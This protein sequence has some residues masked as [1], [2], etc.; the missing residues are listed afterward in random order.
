MDIAEFVKNF[1][2]NEKYNFKYNQKVGGTYKNIEIL[3][4]EHTA[5]VVLEDG[6]EITCSSAINI[7]VPIIIGDNV[8]ITSHSRIALHNVIHIGNNV[9]FITQSD[10]GNVTLNMTDVDSEFETFKTKIG[11]NLTISTG[12][13]DSKQSRYKTVITIT[14]EDTSYINTCNLTANSILIM[15]GL[16]TIEN[17]IFDRCKCA[18]FIVDNYK[19]INTPTYINVCTDNT[20]QLDA[21]EI[22]SGSKIKAG[23]FMYNEYNGYTPNGIIGNDVNIITKDSSIKLH[24]HSIGKNVKLQSDTMVKLCNIATLPNDICIDTQMLKCKEVSKF[25]NNSK[26]I[27][28][29]QVYLGNIVNLPSYFT[30]A[31]IGESKEDSIEY[32]SI[33]SIRSIPSTFPLHADCSLSINKLDVFDMYFPKSISGSLYL[34]IAHIPSNF[35]VNVGGKL[36]V[37]TFSIA[38]N[39]APKVGGDM[40]IHRATILGDKFMPECN[41]KLYI[42]NDVLLKANIFAPKADKIVL[43]VKKLQANIDGMVCNKFCADN[44][45][46][47]ETDFSKCVIKEELSL[48]KASISASCDFITKYIPVINIPRAKIGAGYKFEPK[49]FVLYWKRP[50]TDEHIKK[51]ILVKQLERISQAKHVNMIK[52]PSLTS[53]LDIENNNIVGNFASTTSDTLVNN[54]IKHNVEVLNPTTTVVTCNDKTYCIADGITSE[55]IN[56]DNNARSLK[57]RNII[58][59]E[60]N[61][62]V[63]NDINY[64]VYNDIYSAHG[65][66][67][68]KATL[69]LIFKTSKR[70]IEEYNTVDVDDKFTIIEMC[71]MYRIITGACNAGIKSFMDGYSID[72]DDE[73]MITPND[74]IN[75]NSETWGKIFNYDFYGKKCFTSFFNKKEQKE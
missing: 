36:D 40:Y 19:Y 7:E 18:E 70:T 11:V 45:L 16:S 9:K 43:N 42:Y 37:A 48:F 29:R 34:A 8:T 17:D 68:K 44:L 62:I 2:V 47:V 71:A 30:P 32:L 54:T 56:R 35:K 72:V 25:N 4:S 26:T 51:E 57:V 65:E 38:G 73:R 24:V 61:Y 13:S 3:Q 28:A 39:F 21:I 6:W 63:Y 53:M 74:I 12:I 5:P 64:I 20:L 22:A 33:E 75:G 31:A 46:N 15:G 59:G 69:D 27:K 50:N 23:A 52:T 55:V 49:C 1:T 10:W 58:D 66:S 60:I 14:A 67:I 41:G